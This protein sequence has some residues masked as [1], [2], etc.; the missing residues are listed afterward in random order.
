[1]A[2]FKGP[3]KF[4]GKIGNI[5]Y[6]EVPGDDRTYAAERGFVSKNIL[7]HSPVF[8]E[9]RKTRAEFSPQS[10]CAKDI[11]KALGDWSKPIINRQLHSMLISI[12]NDIV[13]LDKEHDKGHRALYLSKYKNLLFNVDYH[14]LKPLS[15]ILRCPYTVEPEENRNTVTVTI[16]GLNPSKQIK[17]PALAT[18]FQLC[19]GLGT[20]KD[21]VYNE[22][23]KDWEPTPNQK[24]YLN[25]QIL[26]TW[27]P[28]DSGLLEDIT[29]SVSI[30][31]E[32]VI[33]DDITVIRGFG[34]RF[35]RMTGEVVLLEQERGS[36]AFLGP[37]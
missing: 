2:T 23:L 20:V 13:Q 27:I 28:I 29:L 26:H 25:N 22:I 17:A 7:D 18:H 16:K 5:R 12:L 1:M 6:Y 3:F 37:R 15:E 32:D 8:A 31:E 10:R 30:P 35:G 24:F 19:L 34:I 33:G 14:F 11:R 4:K 21:Y 9:S 36:I